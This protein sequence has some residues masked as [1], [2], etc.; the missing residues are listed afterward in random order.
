MGKGTRH[1]GQLALLCLLGLIF[2]GLTGQ[3]WAC[4]LYTSPEL[5]RY[6]QRL[7]ERGPYPDGAYAL[8]QRHETS[9][10]L[11]QVQL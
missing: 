6:L 4:L 8:W 1:V 7:L 5:L 3:I 10:G 2:A 11:Y 9:G